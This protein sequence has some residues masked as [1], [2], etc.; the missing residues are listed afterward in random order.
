MTLCLKVGKCWNGTKT[1]FID[2]LMNPETKGN[3]NLLPELLTD[4]AADS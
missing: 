2:S 1:L 4:N 3:S